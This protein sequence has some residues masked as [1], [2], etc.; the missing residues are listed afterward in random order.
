MFYVD[1]LAIVLK[2]EER[3]DMD[4]SFVFF[5]EKFGK[6]DVFAKGA[7]KI[8]AKLSPHLLLG[9]FVNLEIVVKTKPR[10]IG[11]EVKNNF[12]FMRKNDFALWQVAND[13]EFFNKLI[14]SPEKDLKI[15]KLLLNY[16]KIIDF[17]SK[18]HSDG[19]YISLASLF[20]KINLVNL[21][22]YF[23][24]LEEIKK[25]KEFNTL[26]KKII[27]FLAKKNNFTDLFSS[28]IKQ[29]EKFNKK[30]LE[31]FNRKIKNYFNKNIS[32]I[33]I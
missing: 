7:R 4:F 9:N 1:T 24:D 20:F 22:G 23:P 3:Q 19:F 32:Y 21:L 27:Y 12:S 16:L 29:T 28:K 5:T 17:L 31:K 30:E 8:N 2:K 14:V 18:R 25:T 6:L 33:N 10:L 11:A 13:L 15:W 26:Q